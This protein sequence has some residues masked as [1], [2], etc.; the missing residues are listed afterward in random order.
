MLFLSARKLSDLYIYERPKRKKNLVDSSL[1]DEES[2]IQQY[3][4]KFVL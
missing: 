1:T 2:Y 4:I 3:C